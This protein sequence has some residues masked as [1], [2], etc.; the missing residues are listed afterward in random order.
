MSSLLSV[1]W[2]GSCCLAARPQRECAR[3]PCGTDIWCRTT[4]SG[5]LVCVGP[6]AGFARLAEGG[7]RTWLCLQG[8]CEGALS[9]WRLA[10]CAC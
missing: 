9:G 8:V 6:A 10:C 7:Q 1:T 3:H 5:L 4:H 2:N